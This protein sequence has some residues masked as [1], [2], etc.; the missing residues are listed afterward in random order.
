MMIVHIFRT[1]QTFLYFCITR[2]MCF[3]TSP[4][5]KHN[6]VFCNLTLQTNTHTHTAHTPMSQH[7]IWIDDNFIAHDLWPQFVHIIGCCPYNTSCTL[8]RKLNRTILVPTMAVSMAGIEARCV[9]QIDWAQLKQNPLDTPITKC[10][11]MRT[12]NRMF[13]CFVE[14]GLPLIFAY[15]VPSS[16]SSS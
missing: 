11:R 4:D 1:I 10:M 15:C 14:F 2:L 5:E 16:S 9:D 13:D 3:A 8:I 12:P 6:S 7:L